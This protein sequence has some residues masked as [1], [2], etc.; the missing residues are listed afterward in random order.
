MQSQMRTSN[1]ISFSGR[2]LPMGILVLLIVIGGC[3]PHQVA[4]RWRDETITANGCDAEWQGTP[5]YYDEDRQVTIRLT[6]DGEALFLC[7]AIGDDTLKRQIGMTG[8]TVWVDP[9]GETAQTFAIHLPGRGAGSLH[10]Y[11]PPEAGTGRPAGDWG[12]PGDNEERPDSPEPIQS[13][14]ITYPD[15]TGSLDMTIDEIRRTGIDVG[16]GQAE[17]GR[18]VYEFIIAFRAAPCLTGIAPGMRVGVGFQTGEP[19]KGGHEKTG[20]VGQ[21]GTGGPPGGMGGHGPGRGGGMGRGSGKSR[22]IEKD[23]PFDVW[24][25]ARLADRA[26]G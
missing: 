7:I 12:D 23:D 2:V 4:T 22:S 6:N 14:A 11:P 3:A 8:L 17:G 10:R 16:A 25:E 21:R 13:L 5:D 19:K 24:I 18:W 9:L 1:P 20:A 26:A 15:T